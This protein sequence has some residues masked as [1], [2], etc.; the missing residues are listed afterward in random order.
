MYNIYSKDHRVVLAGLDPDPTFPWTVR[1]RY[2]GKPKALFPVIDLLEK[3]ED[4]QDILVL[5]EDPEALWKDFRELFTPV[6]AA[7]GLVTDPLGKML[8]IV[9]NGYLDLPKG[10]L[11]PGEDHVTAAL[12]EVEEETGLDRLE[13]SKEAA[14]TW[15]I[16]R[17]VKRRI[18]KRTIWYA[19]N[20]KNTEGIPQAEEG[21]SALLWLGP[22][23][24]TTSPMPKFRNITEMLSSWCERQGVSD[25]WPK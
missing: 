25:C 16:Y 4:R 11:D 15:H 1:V 23:D 18:L 20:A 8:F 14:N 5:A 24:Y 19:M 22:E 12:R 6:E 2:H 7:G 3:R 10:K 13:L 21:I 9:R 17:E